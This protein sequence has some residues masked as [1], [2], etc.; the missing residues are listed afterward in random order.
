ME[1]PTSVDDYLAGLPDD[2]RAVLEK[3]RATIRAA[4]P[5]ATEKISYG[6]PTFHL[7]GN[8]VYYAAFKDHCSFFPGSTKVMAD[9]A[10]DLAPFE[11]SKGTIRFSVDRPLPSALVK[12]MVKERIAENESKRRR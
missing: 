6:M 9:H 1:K 3:L 11:V 8:L 4:A 7:N 10:E 2:E 12:K 5:T